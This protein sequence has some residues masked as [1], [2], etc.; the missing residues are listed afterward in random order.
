MVFNPFSRKRFT[1]H[2][3][4]CPNTGQPP[5]EKNWLREKG[6]YLSKVKYQVMRPTS[7]PRQS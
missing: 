6:G 7:S 4:G 1:E 3:G 2:E 5:F